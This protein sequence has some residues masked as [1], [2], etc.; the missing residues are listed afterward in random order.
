MCN[1]KACWAIGRLFKALHGWRLGNARLLHVN[2]TKDEATGQALILET[3]ENFQYLLFA[4]LDSPQHPT[5]ESRVLYL[6]HG[7]DS[8]MAIADTPFDGLPP[9]DFVPMARAEV[10]GVYERA[11]QIGAGSWELGTN[12]NWA[13]EPVSVRLEPGTYPKGSRRTAD[14]GIYFQVGPPAPCLPELD[15]AADAWDPEVWDYFQQ[16]AEAS[17][18]VALQLCAAALLSFQSGEFQAELG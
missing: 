8:E 10:T 7:F 5:R 14:P 13:V 11:R 2:C 4:H 3:P 6:G 16:P 18:Q 1:G 9:E 12:P 17:V 15:P